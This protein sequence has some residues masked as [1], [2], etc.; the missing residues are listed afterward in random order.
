[1]QVAGTRKVGRKKAAR[2][3]APKKAG[4]SVSAFARSIGVSHTAV[5]KA[6]AT[7]RLKGSVTKGARGPRIVDVAL[8]K[9][10]WKTGVSKPTKPKGNGKGKSGGGLL[11][12]AQHQVAVERARGLRMTNALKAGELV[13]VAKARRESF[14]AART[15]RDNVLNIPDRVSAELAGETDAR[16][17]HALLKA[18]LEKALESVAEILEDG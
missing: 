16:R 9:K 11:I 5:Q 18:E 17:V 2:K 14:N 3:A 12:E 8:A 1:M 4:V 7:G 13:E 10:E 15:V 6:I